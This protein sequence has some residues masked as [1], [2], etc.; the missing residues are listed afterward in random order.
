MYR[1]SHLSLFAWA[2]AIAFALGMAFW[3]ALTPFAAAQAQSAPDDVTPPV[4]LKKFIAIDSESGTQLVTE[5]V[6]TGNPVRFV[7]T[8]TNNHTAAVVALVRDVLP[9]GLSAVAANAGNCPA[10]VTDDG[11]AAMAALYLEPGQ[12]RPFVIKAKLTAEIGAAQ[13]LTNTAGS[14]IIPTPLGGGGINP[15]FVE[16]AA[17]QGIGCGGINPAFVNW[18]AVPD[19]P[20]VVS[21]PA[22]VK[23]VAPDLG[24]APDSTNHAAQLMRAYVGAN[25]AAQYPTVFDPTTGLPSG[26]YHRNA[27]PLHL[28]MQV[29]SELEADI[30]PDADAVNNI[31]PMPANN[32]RANRDRYDDG[33]GVGQISFADCQAATIPVRVFVSPQAVQAFQQQNAKAKLNVWLDSDRNGDWTGSVACA[34][35]QA[36]EHIVINAD[37]DVVALGAGIH[38]LSFTSGLVSW[39]AAMADKPAW[40][41]VTLSEAPA[42]L[43]LNDGVA[44]GDGRGPTAGYNVGETEDYYYLAPTAATAA[45]DLQISI[46][47][48]VPSF[49]G[50]LPQAG[51]SAIDSDF[52][53]I[54]VTVR[55]RNDG[56]KTATNSLLQFEI[57]LFNG[58]QANNAS[59]ASMR[60]L[61][62]GSATFNGCTAQVNLGDVAPGESRAILLTQLLPSPLSFTKPITISVTVPDAL[63]GAAQTAGESASQAKLIQQRVDFP[64]RPPILTN[65]INGTSNTTTVTFRGR[66]EPNVTLDLTLTAANGAET[67]IPVPVNS[68]GRFNVPVTLGPG[69][70][71]YTLGWTGCLT[72]TVM[73]A[74]TGAGEGDATGYLVVDPTLPW[75][76]LSLSFVDASGRVVRPA[77]NNGRLDAEGW[78][79]TLNAS[80]PYTVWLQAAGC[81]AVEVSANGG[82]SFVALSPALLDGENGVAGQIAT[83]ASGSQSV[84]VKGICGGNPVDLG[85]GTLVMRSSEGIVTDATTG[86]ALA[87]ATVSALVAN[88]NAESGAGGDVYALWSATDYGQTNPQVTGG[89]GKFGFYPPAGTYQLSAVRSGYQPYRSPD[90][91]LAGGFLGYAIGLTPATN[92]AADHVI[93]ITESGFVPGVL[94]ASTGDVI[95]FVNVDTGEH[96]VRSSAA[97]VMAAAADQW[98]SGLLQ[99]GERYTVVVTGEGTVSFA[100][101]A[102]PQFSGAIVV[103]AAAPTLYLPS[104]M[105]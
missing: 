99:T 28:G 54:K 42:P 63:A 65:I 58:C 15:T 105:R 31:R 67:T 57:Q 2:A 56:N 74:A 64:M 30:G 38:S 83:V 11:A 9:A 59:I 49:G 7:V 25:I 96:V 36:R 24:D 48:Q 39:P 89:D 32:Q 40:L 66:G 8:A 97:G 27:A 3:L 19:N 103:S 10:A 33:V 80:E 84:Q 72:C 55:V 62:A 71:D 18:D 91:P 45:P 50:A 79:A 20:P 6:F 75:N 68:L 35:G 60:V 94:S 101:A 22:V 14:T 86:A 52:E 78:Q 16:P 51:A 102:Q 53:E 1:K 5:T 77:G 61:P 17:I 23:I 85:S 76:P 44:Y 88:A 87:S 98:D 46:G 43:P 47:A 26:P 73:A 4:V 82:Q 95:E 100:D 81:T 37:V 34:G 93:Q 41:R 92:E 70:Y 90:L 12:T 13:A 29:S 21:N 69:P 104:V